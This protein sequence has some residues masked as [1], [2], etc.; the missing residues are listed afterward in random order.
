[1]KVILQQDI[2]GSGKKGDLVEVSDGY[3]R[4]YLFPRKLAAPADAANMNEYKQKEAAKAFHK[5]QE[6]EAAQE[7]AKKLEGITVK[8]SAKGGSGGRLFGSVTAK[9]V[10][11]LAGK[12]IGIDVDKKKLQMEDI[13]AFGTYEVE[14]RVYPGIAAK[15]FVTVVEA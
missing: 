4:N 15:F 12:Q 13:K 8:V 1:M 5:Q 11:E 9:E 3:A 7:L 14:A 2:K 6:L 10:A